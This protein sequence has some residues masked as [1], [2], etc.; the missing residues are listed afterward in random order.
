MIISAIFYPY[1]FKDIFN[2]DY[3]FTTIYWFI[4]IIPLEIASA[5]FF[6][7]I[8]YMIMIIKKRRKD[9]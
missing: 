1:Y 4:F 8:T 9:A 3:D 5:L 6:T 7:G 2:N